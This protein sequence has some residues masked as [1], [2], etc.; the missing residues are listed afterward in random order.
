MHHI[1]ATEEAL[2]EFQ[3]RSEEI[4]RFTLVKTRGYQAGKDDWLLIHKKDEDADPN[5]DVDAL[6]RVRIV[7][8]D[9]GGAPSQSS[10]RT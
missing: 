9:T 8:E 7:G 4:G 3:Q 5:W 2:R 10:S 6:P 1:G